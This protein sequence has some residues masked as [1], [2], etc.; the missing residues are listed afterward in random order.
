MATAP[1]APTREL[2]AAFDTLHQNTLGVRAV[3]RPGKDAHLLS[4]LWRSHESMILKLMEDFFSSDD[5]FI[6]ENGY[7]VG[8]F[9]SQAPKL[10]ARRQRSQRETKEPWWDECARVHQSTCEKAL[11]HYTRMRMD[12]KDDL[13]R[14]VM[15]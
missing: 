3:I 12:V 10:I 8:M 7:S 6:T 9:V 4:T 11:Q 13:D 14:K 15:P 5:P 2:L 1:K